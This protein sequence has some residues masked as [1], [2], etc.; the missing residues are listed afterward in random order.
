MGHERHPAPSIWPVSLAT[1]VTLAAAGVLTSWV[2]VVAGLLL[3][4]VAVGGWIAESL[5]EGS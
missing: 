3:A 1:G 5:E 4:A 2:L